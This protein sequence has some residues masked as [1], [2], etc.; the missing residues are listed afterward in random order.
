MIRIDMEK[1]LNGFIV[2]YTVNGHAGFAPEGQ[3]IICSAVSTL[4]M[5]AINGLEEHL[6]REV[7][8]EISDGH[9]QVELKQTP[10]DLS[11]AILAT[12]EIGLKDLAEQYPKRVRIQE[13]RR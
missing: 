1:N 9:M 2:G 12:M 10:D 8:Y 6:H 7:S 5:V 4:T 13:H 11:Q 3:D